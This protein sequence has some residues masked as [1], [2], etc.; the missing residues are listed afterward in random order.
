MASSSMTLEHWRMFFGGF[1]SDIFEVM[2]KTILVAA[3]DFPEEFKRRRGEIVGKLYGALQPQC[4][5][6]YCTGKEEGGGLGQSM[7]EATKVSVGTGSEGERKTEDKELSEDKLLAMLLES[8]NTILVTEQVKNRRMTEEKGVKKE[9]IR[10]PIKLVNSN[11]KEKVELNKKK[12]TDEDMLKVKL[13]ASKRKLREGYQQAHDAQ[14]T[15]GSSAPYMNTPDARSTCT[16]GNQAIAFISTV[17]SQSQL[18]R[19]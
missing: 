10:P 8:D 4:N 13:E 15:V 2:E 11:S 7:N 12:L 9:K 17:R 16:E 14:V 18:A 5:Q 3:A 1:P 19:I 6:H